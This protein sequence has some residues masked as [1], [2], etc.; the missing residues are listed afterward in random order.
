[1]IPCPHCQNLL[2]EPPPAQ[3]PS[4]GGVV[5]PASEPPLPPIPDEPAVPPP[6]PAEAGKE[7]TG[8]DDH[9][10]DTGGF[11]H[12]PGPPHAW[13]ERDRLG[14]ATAFVETTRQLLTA[15][16][17]FFREMPVT[18]G[19]GSPLL[20]AVIVGWIGLTAAAFYQAV[21]VSI[22]GPAA[23]PFG[24]DRG[25]FADTLRWLES[26]VGLVAQVVFGGISVAIA[27]FVGSG[28]LHLMLLMLGGAR[29][30]FEASFRVVCFSQATALLLL[31]PLFLIPLCG[32]V[33]VVWCLALCVI[34]LAE[35]HRIG[36]GK[37]LAAVLLP[38]LVVCCC[39]AALAFSFVGAVAGLVEQMR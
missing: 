5:S 10:R 6:L 16:T 7:R 8:L 39:C 21:W 33:G 24:L 11:T 18:G 30:G 22:A 15:P 2:P 3:C 26:W 27:V 9:A 34:G 1:M 38:L 32:L 13:D 29:R 25:E 14:F 17:S 19:L 28:I 23:L 37:S 4:C 12:P 35:A 36:Y 31:I 20:Y